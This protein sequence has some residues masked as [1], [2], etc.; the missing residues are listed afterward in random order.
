MKSI[1][2]IKAIKSTHCTSGSLAKLRTYLTVIFV[3]YLVSALFLLASTAKTSDQTITN[4]L[5][6]AIVSQSVRQKS[7]YAMY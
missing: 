2:N 4:F 1:K 6:A 7:A 5:C 3:F